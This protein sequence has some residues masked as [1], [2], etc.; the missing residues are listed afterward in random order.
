MTKFKLPVLCDYA[1][2]RTVTF[3]YLW[4]TEKLWLL[5]GTAPKS[6]PLKHYLHYYQS[7]SHNSAL[8]W[9]LVGN[10]CLYFDRLPFNRW[11]KLFNCQILSRLAFGIKG[12]SSKTRFISSI[13]R[14]FCIA[15]WHYV[16]EHIIYTVYSDYVLMFA[17]A[18]L[19]CKRKAALNRTFSTESYRNWRKSI[20]IL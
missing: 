14:L 7:L 18:F 11:L 1:K 2:W 6:S 13:F 9:V 5:G 15:L 17:F 19:S 10:K 16:R 12:C 8:S 20:N 3:C 4:L